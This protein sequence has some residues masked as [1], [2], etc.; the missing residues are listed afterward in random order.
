VKARLA[1]LLGSRLVRQNL[2]LFAGGLVAGLGGFVYHAIA[3]RKLGPDL[4]G[5]V[6]ALVSLYSVGTAIALVLIL[7][8]ARY[9]AGLRLEGNEGGIRYLAVRTELLLILPSLVLLGLTW[10]LS[11]PAVAFLHL[12][13]PIA[14]WLLG[15]AVVGIWQVSIP[16]GILQGIQSFGALAANLSL[17][18]VVRTAVLAVL[19]AVGFQAGGAMAAIVAGVAFAYLLGIFNL[20]GLAGVEPRRV[21]LRAM[22]GF[23]LTAAAGTLGILV[24]YNLD[25]ILAKHY[26]DPHSAGI[27]GGINKVETILYFLTLSVGQVLFPRV[28]EAVARND[29]PGR[30]LLLSSGI[31]SLLGAGAILVFALVPKLVITLLFGSRGFGDAVPYVFVMGVIGLGL[32]LDNLLVQFLMAVHDRVFIPVL[33]AACVLEAVLLV[34]LHASLAQ[35]VGDVFAVIFLLFA[36]L[37]VRCLVLLPRLR[38]EM[39]VEEPATA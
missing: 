24:L 2:V 3:A 19:L 18:M 20:R 23:S 14:I 8:L 30:L 28:V 4:Y 12:R 13:G 35:V 29:H 6:A 15:L 5:E 33:A 7:V 1:A 17:E 37:L 9:A 25:V 22:A 32:S 10:L 34:A 27:Y 21:Q 38:P 36:G 16:R 11:A 31:T 26:L 39:L